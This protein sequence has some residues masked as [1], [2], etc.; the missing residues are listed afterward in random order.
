MLESTR[1]SFKKAN[2][3]D[4]EG[5]GVPVARKYSVLTEIIDIFTQACKVCIHDED[6]AE[7]DF[8]HTFE[9]PKGFR[10]GSGKPCASTAGGCHEM[11]YQTTATSQPRPSFLDFTFP[12]LEQLA[13][14]FGH[15]QA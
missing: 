15:C 7:T 1:A 11:V 4:D 13:G 8:E 2:I 10:S 12:F 6:V 3:L 14:S 5:I 9:T